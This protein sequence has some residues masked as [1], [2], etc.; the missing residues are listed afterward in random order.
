MSH[1]VGSFVHAPSRPLVIVSTPLPLPELFTQPMPWCSTGQPSGSGPT[2]SGSTAPWHLPNVWPP[3][4]RATVSSSSI[5]MRAKVSRMSRAE[6]IG[7]G[8]AFG[9]SGFT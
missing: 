4:M 2:N 1:F 3:T 9:P 7:S 6:A 5:A 8:L